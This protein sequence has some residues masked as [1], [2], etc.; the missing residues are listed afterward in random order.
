M[1][2][3][4][5]EHARPLRVLTL[6]RNYPNSV[7]PLLG[8][9][10]QQLVR[11]T[12]RLCQV[13]V[14]SPVPYVPPWPWLPEKYRRFGRVETH[15]KEGAV[16]VYHP[17]FIVPPGHRFYAFESI[18]YWLGVNGP[19]DDLRGRFAFD[20]IHAHFTYPDGY[21]AARL[22][23]RYGVP[24]VITEQASWRPW[25]DRYPMVRRRAIWASRQAAF[26]IAISKALR[27]TIVHFTGESSRLV[28]IPD[29]VDTSVFTLPAQS[30]HTSPTQIL[31]V[32]A[33]RAVK[34]VDILL[35]S[36]R[37]L[38]DRGRALRLVL[39]GESFY[40]GYR[41]DFEGVRQLAEDLSLQGDVEFVG[42]KSLSEL[43]RYMQQ[44]ALLV[45]PSRRETLGM[46]LIEALACGTPVVATRCGGPEDIVTDEVGVLVPPEDPTALAG[47]IE[48]VL[49]RR[50]LYRPDVLRAHVVSNFGLESVTDRVYDLYRQAVESGGPRPGRNEAGAV[51]RVQ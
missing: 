32:G 33:I 24:V 11:G 48:R 34:G 43:V 36:V 13:Q 17:R 2:F 10:V 45:L 50:G 30:A 1:S 5:G 25:M 29:G 38:K 18:P 19:I 27:E 47:G 9:W 12:A 16:D 15:R 39:V 40:E 8:L 51:S 35:R 41:R 31:F 49:D 42:K 14:V 3:V 26:H 44:S 28:V 20:L 21:V 23:H 37:L 4:P 22:G 46:V 7:F 6:S